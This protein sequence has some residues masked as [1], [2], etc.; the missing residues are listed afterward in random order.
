MSARTDE[1]VQLVSAVIGHDDWLLW[2]TAIAGGGVSP[3]DR[4]QDM[5]RRVTVCMPIPLALAINN[6]SSSSIRNLYVE[7]HFSPVI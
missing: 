1:A 7:L 3:K 2:R 6:S 4:E 5:G